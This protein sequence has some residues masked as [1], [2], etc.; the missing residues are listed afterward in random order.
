MAE[1]AYSALELMV[2]LA[3]RELAGEQVIFVGVGLPNLAANLARRTV[4]PQLELVY[5]SGIF[6]A[7]PQRLPLSIGDPAL[8]SG[9]AMVCGMPDLF[10]YFLQGGHI[11][12]GFLGGA[13]IDRY[14]N[15]NTT[16]IG[17]YEQPQV[18]LPGSG[19][20]CEIALLAR[21]ILIVSPLQ[22]RRFPARVDFITSPG[23]GSG[24][25]RRGAG[26]TAVIT[27]L[28]ILR[29]HPSTQEMMLSALHPGVTVAQVQ[30]EVGWPLRVAE[31]L[32]RSSPPTAEE[33]HCLRHEVDSARLY[34]R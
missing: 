30:A 24:A 26:P 9:A 27:D 12:V 32:T 4:A 10:L 33:L 8:V 34:L 18:R 11:D 3:A 25:Q 5:E 20:A 7:D 23:H 19:G 29:F 1:P 15:L 31:P 6:G 28:G 2:I 14:G 21:K 17:P 16:V 13:Q 22:R